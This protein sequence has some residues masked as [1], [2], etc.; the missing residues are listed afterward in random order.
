MIRFLYL[1]CHAVLMV[2][3]RYGEELRKYDRFIIDMVP[4][5]KTL[6]L[7]L[8]LELREITKGQ[9]NLK[10]LEI[11]CGEGELTK[12]VLYYNKN[13]KLDA[14]D[15]SDEMISVSRNNVKEYSDRINFICE[16]V[17]VF[18]KKNVKYDVIFTS[19]TIHNFTKTEQKH[20]LELIFNALNENGV[21]LIMDKFY[22]DDKSVQEDLLQ[23]QLQ[24]Y[25]YMDDNSRKSVYEHEQQDFSDEYKLE[26]SAGLKILKNIGFKDIS[27]IDRV[28]RD[29]VI[30]AKK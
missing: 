4:S 3:N 19:W 20:I 17:F 24:R 28:E 18:L 21:F 27:L 23:N 30:V 5:N 15:I 25:K 12:D 8:A 22:P 29:V 13:I 1:P 2:L 6:K 26:E 9:N 10:V 16:D 14:L 7:V 11:G